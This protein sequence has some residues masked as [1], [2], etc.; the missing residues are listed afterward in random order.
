MCHPCLTC[1]EAEVGSGDLIQEILGW[2]QGWG[3]L[4][5]AVLA[6]AKA[7]GPST[8]PELA[9]ARSRDP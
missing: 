2:V 6:A 5:K 1:I 4:G 7:R 3:K 9:G 8:N